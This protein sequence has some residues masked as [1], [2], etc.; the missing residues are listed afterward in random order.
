M[1]R[2]QLRFLLHKRYVRVGELIPDS[3]GLM[4]DNH[5]N[6]FRTGTAGGG[7]RILKQRFP[8]QNMQNLRPIRFHTNA[9]TRRQ[10]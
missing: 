3:L 9:F 2:P 10:D 4:A 1:T 7:K 8:V 6:F 5:D